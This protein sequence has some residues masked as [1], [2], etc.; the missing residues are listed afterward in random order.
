MQAGIARPT[1]ALRPPWLTTPLTPVH[2][3]ICSESHSGPDDPLILPC[4]CATHPSMQSAHPCLLLLSHSRAPHTPVHLRICFESHSG[5]VDPLISPCKCAGSSQYI[6]R[7]C[8]RKWRESA[9][10]NPRQGPALRAA[11]EVGQGTRGDTGDTEPRARSC[12][13][14]EGCGWEGAGRL[15][16]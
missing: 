5:P 11:A 1:C 15:G 8:L 4:N 7:H 9:L 13:K 6:H 3:R 14:C 2:L 10:Q 16:L 12:C